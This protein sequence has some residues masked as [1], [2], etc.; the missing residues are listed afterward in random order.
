MQLY[1]LYIKNLFDNIVDNFFCNFNDLD[2][3]ENFSENKVY[4]QELGDIFKYFL[5]FQ[6]EEFFF[7][8]SNFFLRYRKKYSIFFYFFSLLLDVYA[9]VMTYLVSHLWLSTKIYN[10]YVHNHYRRSFLKILGIF[11]LIFSLIFLGFYFFII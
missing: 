7:N 6:F 11:F 1:V 9:I 10:D 2:L 8:L 4:F 3:L 5:N